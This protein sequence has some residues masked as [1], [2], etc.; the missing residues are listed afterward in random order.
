ML[1]LSASIAS[2][3]VLMRLIEHV[4]VWAERN[5]L[6]ISVSLYRN[7]KKLKSSRSHSNNRAAICCATRLAPAIWDEF[8]DWRS[9]NKKS[10]PKP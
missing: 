7:T 2:W 10:S 5:E 4:S 8:V 9:E 6:Q 1:R 3:L